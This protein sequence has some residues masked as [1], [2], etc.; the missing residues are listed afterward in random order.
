MIHSSLLEACHLLYL[1]MY[2]IDQDF[3]IL[4]FGVYLHIIYCIRLYLRCIVHSSQLHTCHLLSS[5]SLRWN[6]GHFTTRVWHR[7]LGELKC[8]NNFPTFYWFPSVHRRLPMPLAPP[9]PL[10]SV[11]SGIGNC[12][13]ECGDHSTA[14]TRDALPA[15]R[16]RSNL[17][18]CT[19]T[20]TTSPVFFKNVADQSP[21]V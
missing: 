2:Y 19:A 4:I 11:S 20:T 10:T 3:P 15:G 18:V 13:S 21:K 5:C 8:D 6:E 17:G 1:V 9:C 16:G 12:G 7:H 14:A